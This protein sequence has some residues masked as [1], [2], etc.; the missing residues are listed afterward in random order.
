MT[1]LD[2]AVVAI[3]GTELA[4]VDVEMMKKIVVGNPGAAETDTG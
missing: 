4:E 3:I 1:A 2:V